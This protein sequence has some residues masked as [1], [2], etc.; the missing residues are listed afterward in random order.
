LTWYRGNGIIYGIMDDRTIRRLRKR[1]DKLRLQAAGVRPRQLKALAVSVGRRQ[2]KGGKHPTFVKEPRVPLTIPDHR[3][4]NEYTVG[5]IL[6]VLEE[7]LCYE[8]GMKDV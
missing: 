7:D 5:N 3:K 8:E 2:R 4:M 1:I 6:D